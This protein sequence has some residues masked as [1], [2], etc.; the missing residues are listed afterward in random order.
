MKSVELRPAYQWTCEECGQDNFAAAICPDF[1]EEDMQEMRDDHGI[2]PW[3]TG[4]WLQMPTVVTCQHC[5]TVFSTDHYEE[6]T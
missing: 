2:Q 3:E 5:F 6:N 4:V 1:S